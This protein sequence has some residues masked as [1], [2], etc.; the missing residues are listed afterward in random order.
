MRLKARRSD[1][2][3]PAG[4]G[5][6]PVSARDWPAGERTVLC[7]LDSCAAVSG[8]AEIVPGDR[9]RAA[10]CLMC[11]EAIGAALAQVVLLAHLPSGPGARG[12]LV[13]RGYLIHAQHKPREPQALH[14]AAH[15]LENPGCQRGCCT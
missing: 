11:G 5:Y 2:Y 9:L 8:P 14:R 4:P 7:S 15:R 3:A 13:T 10:P 6:V 1:R 12:R